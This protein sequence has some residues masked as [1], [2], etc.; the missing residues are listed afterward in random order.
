MQAMV[1]NFIAKYNVLIF[2]SIALSMPA[3]GAQSLFA[4]T[5]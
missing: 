2:S 5:L 4:G 3:I 1:C